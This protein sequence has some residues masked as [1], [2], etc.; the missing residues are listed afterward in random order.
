MLQGVSSDQGSDRSQKFV[1]RL[2]VNKRYSALLATV[3]VEK[4]KR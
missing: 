3:K 4:R 1:D 2:E